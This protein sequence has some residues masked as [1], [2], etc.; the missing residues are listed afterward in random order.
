MKKVYWLFAGD[1]LKPIGGLVDYRGAYD[2][3]ETALAV[4]ATIPYDWYE[5]VTLGQGG[6]L[7]SVARGEK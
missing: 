2:S 3:P 5:I 7:V 6:G 4:L 1:Y